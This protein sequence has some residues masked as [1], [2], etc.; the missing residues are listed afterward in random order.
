MF[1][2]TVIIGFFGLLAAALF[3]MFSKHNEIPD[4]LNYSM[5]GVGLGS[6]VI[7]A[8]M[9]E[10]YILILYSLAGLVAAGIF[11]WILYKLNQ[12]G[13]GDAKAIMGIGALLGINF[14]QGFPTLAM[15]VINIF[16][17]GAIIGIFWT[18]YK[19]IKNFKEFKTT[20]KEL[21][22]SK[23][24]IRV[25]I[26][27]IIICAGLLIYGFTQIGITKILSVGFAAII[28]F[29]FYFY[30]FNKAADKSCMKKEMDVAELVEGDWLAEEVKI[31]KKVFAA[32]MTLEKN[33]LETIKKHKKTVVVRVG[34]PFLPSFVIAY[35]ITFL[36]GN[37]LIYL[38]I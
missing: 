3:D 22:R 11:G 23:K 10:K 4:W 30:M 1:P 5:I 20:F 18:I 21:I 26:A 14:S 35:L 36:I 32:K 27:I 7:T 33:D 9:T 29:M 24:I 34:M 6:A 16:I 25:R 17:V 15:F 31:G 19:V 28:F 8:F 2:V 13:G 37:W 12:W 38:V